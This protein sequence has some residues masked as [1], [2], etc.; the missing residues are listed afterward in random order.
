MRGG[1]DDDVAA[2][3]EDR[4]GDALVDDLL[5]RLQHERVLAL[6]VDEALEVGAEARLAASNTGFMTKPERKTKLA[7]FSR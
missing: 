5:G 7:S 2:A 6:G 1:A 4:P 3:D